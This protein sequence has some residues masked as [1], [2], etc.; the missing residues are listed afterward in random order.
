MSVNAKTILAFSAILTCFLAGL[1]HV[2]AVPL[3]AQK[4]ASVDVPK[5]KRDMLEEREIRD[6]EGKDLTDRA[7]STEPEDEADRVSPPVPDR[8]PLPSLR[9]PK[10][11]IEKYGPPSP[12]ETWNNRLI[13]D[14]KAE[15]AQLI[16]ERE[17]SFEALEPLKEGVCGAPAPIILNRFNL[18]PKV[19]IHPS[20][21][22]T[23]PFADALKRWMTE[24]VQPRAKVLLQDE[25]V[26]LT[27]VASY[28]CRARYNDPTRRMSH[29]AFANAIDISEFT[30]AKGEHISLTENWDGDDP[31]SKFLKDIH[32]G[33][34][35]IFGTVLG[36]EANAAHKSHF[37]FDMAQRRFGAFCQ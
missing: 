4:P 29:H 11:A 3:P 37:H 23:C 16:S 18:T 34:C 12:A 30:T 8:A 6:E 15:C 19:E 28:H 2:R 32:D 25:I 24:V 20:P 33:A 10:I 36:P 26:G 27:N 14:A 22:V 9:K 17:Y 21:T 13:T 7:W 1:G 5:K 35:K 31:R